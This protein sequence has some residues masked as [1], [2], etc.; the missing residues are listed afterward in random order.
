MMEC[1]RRRNSCGVAEVYLMQVLTM[2]GS[3]QT[4]AIIGGDKRQL[5]LA[6]SLLSDGY[7]V[8]LAGFDKL[9]AQGFDG[10]SGV[11]AAVLYSDAVILPLPS[12]RVDK[13][14]NAPLSG[15][16]IFFSERE[17]AE[18][19]RKPVF[20]AMRDRLLRAY[21]KLE[22]ARVYDYAARED[23]A[24]RN[25]L[26]TA[27]GAVELAMREY[28]G[29]MAGSRVLVTG[30]GRIGKLLSKLLHALGAD[31]TVCARKPSDIAMIA[32]LGYRSADTRQLREVRNYDLVFNTVP[33]LL[34]DEKLLRNTERTTLLIDLASLPGG[35]DFESAH[36]LD[37]D[38]KRALG[39]PGKCAPKSAGEIIK[40]TVLSMIEEGN[41]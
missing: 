37:I 13:S 14:I 22:D 24:V 34:F 11:E 31:V 20:A 21:P 26:P 7:Q 35:V 36:R 41:R 40:T 15:R 30:F 32:A 33:A 28:E 1:R 9:R 5:F 23:F 18:L 12:V 38:A 4:F 10:L 25:A 19:C 16:S 2:N 29:T 17:Q 8:I 6:Q 39:L 27:E 3:I